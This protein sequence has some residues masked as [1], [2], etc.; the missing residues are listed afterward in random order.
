[1]PA[2]RATNRREVL[3]LMSTLTNPGRVRWKVIEGAMNAHLKAVVTSKAAGL[4]QGQPE[5]GYPQSSAQT[6]IAASRMMRSFQH[7]TTAMRH[8]SSSFF[9]DQ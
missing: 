1:M 4:G 9:S 8:E 7:A 3:S 6:A 2:I 5:E